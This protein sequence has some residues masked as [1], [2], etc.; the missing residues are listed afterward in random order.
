MKTTFLQTGFAALLFIACITSANAYT[1]VTSGNWSNSAT[2]GGN[3]PGASVSNQDI[4]I[5]PDITVTLDMDVTFSGVNN[6]FIV[7]GIL[8]NATNNGLLISQ[9]IL[10][11]NGALAIHQLSFG[12]LATIGYTGTLYA[13]NFVNAGA[14]LLIDFIAVVSDTLNLEAGSV[15]L[16]S[17]GN[18]L[19]MTNGTVRVNTGTLTLQGGIF[20]LAGSYD[21]L[22]VGASKI[23]SIE[24][25]ASGLRN[26]TIQLSDNTQ[27]ITLTSNIALSGNLQLLSGRVDFSNQRL[28]INGDVQ[29]QTGTLLTANSESSLTIQSPGSLTNPLVFSPHSGLGNLIIAAGSRATVKLSSL[30]NLFN[31]LELVSGVLSVEAD[32]ALILNTGTSVL[33]QSG[34]LKINNGVFSAA[35]PYDLKYSGASTTTGVE[36]TGSGLNNMTIGLSSASNTVTLGD[37]ISIAGTLYLNNGNMDL[38]AKDLTLNGS[39]SSQPGASFVGN[40]NSEVI[41]NL[42]APPTGIFSLDASNRNLKVLQVNIAGGGTVSLGTD[43]F[44][45][46]SL[47]LTSGK[48]DIGDNNLTIGPAANLTGYSNYRYIITSGLGS[49]HEQV[50]QSGPVVTFPVG[51]S[52]GYSPAILQQGASGTSG[53]FSV[54]TSNGVLTNGTSGYNGA[55]STSMV[56]RTWF[57]E[58]DPAVTVGLNLQLAWEA[59]AEVNGFNR[60]Q[61]YIS[62]YTNAAWDNYTLTAATTGS[63]GTY[64]QSRANLTSL[65]PF[66][67]ADP[68]SALGIKELTEQPA[69]KIYPNPASD[70]LNLEMAMPVS[71][72]LFELF[73]VTGQILLTTTGNAPVQQFQVGDLQQGSYFIRITDKASK[74]TTIKQ[75]IKS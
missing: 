11:G 53:D 12:S 68:H 65:S 60:T 25:A 34:V 8:S 58:S 73:D 75:F 23:S 9:G 51:T 67:V 62:H 46:N 59:T 72:Y 40:N 13:N 39:F 28:T 48:I 50:Y 1:A 36:A 24:I 19:L 14:N 66:A 32:G 16:N 63:F 44:I 21:V 41:L 69:F 47:V 6:S 30:L 54:R 74:Q 7:N 57:I 26:V 33:I 10:S 35:A 15:V 61:S 5:P 27:N 3:A 42:T 70:L 2:W 4:N 31:Q 43:L 38:N 37:P 29:M 55:T 49:L 56:D 17:R 64:V 22:Y 52:S 18:L 45:G 20:A 71:T